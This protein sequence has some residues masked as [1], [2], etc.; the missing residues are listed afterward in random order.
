MGVLDTEYY[1]RAIEAMNVDTS[2]LV[3]VTDDLVYAKSICNVIG[4]SSIIGPH[5]L[6]VLESFAIM[7]FSRNLVCANSTFSWWAGVI[8]I[9]QGGKVYY[10]KPWFLNWNQNPGE[11][12][13]YPRFSAIPST[14]IL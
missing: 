10:P 3:V 12:F 4:V 14:F 1:V 9:N 2:K 5:D 11:S 13:D 8:A 7:A 6:S